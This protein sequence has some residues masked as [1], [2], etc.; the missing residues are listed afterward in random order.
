MS[1]Y[2][3]GQFGGMRIE[4]LWDDLKDLLDGTVATLPYL[5]AIDTLGR[6]E[7]VCFDGDVGYFSI[8]LTP[9]AE[10]AFIVAKSTATPYLNRGPALDTTLVGVGQTLDSVVSAS[11]INI[12]SKS[13]VLLAAPDLAGT[14]HHMSLIEDETIPG[15]YRLAITGKVSVQVAPPPEGGVP[16][17]YFADNP[18]SISQAQSP[19]D[20]DIT[21]PT[22]KILVIQQIIA[23]CQGDPSA[24]GSKTEVVFDDGAEHLIDRIFITGQTQFGNYPDTTEARDGTALTGNGTNKLVLRRSRLSNSGQE[25]DLV[26]RGYLI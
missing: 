6:T 19:H 13:G 14:T 9:A 5:E 2:Q 20:T 18:L 1:N 15:L 4:L 3:F 7:V 12:S 16:V 11:G 21:L 23:G 10:A 24:D 17:T 22:G 25:I 26:V 8:L